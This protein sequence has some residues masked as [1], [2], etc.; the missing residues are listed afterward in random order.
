MNKLRIQQVLDG[1]EELVSDD[2]GSW[3]EKRDLILGSCTES[4][5]TNLFEFI[6]WFEG[7]DE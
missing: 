7:V 2:S 6:A 3:T 1:I 5:K 4:E